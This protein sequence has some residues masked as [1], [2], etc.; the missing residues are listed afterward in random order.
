MPTRLQVNR[1]PFNGMAQKRKLPTTSA[2]PIRHGAARL[3]SSTATPA[4]RRAN[5]WDDA[6]GPIMIERGAATV[7][8]ILSNRRA[9]PM[10]SG[11]LLPHRSSRRVSHN[12]D[13]LENQILVADLILKPLLARW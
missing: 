2:W 8:A 10:P 9:D 3:E 1:H 7:D 6:A 4:G 11:F 13:L 5:R 12:G